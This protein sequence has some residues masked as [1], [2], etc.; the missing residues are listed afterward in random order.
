MHYIEFEYQVRLDHTSFIEGYIPKTKVPYTSK[1]FN[2]T[3]SAKAYI[4]IGGEYFYSDTVTHSYMTIADA[5]LN[6]ETVD[7]GTKTAVQNI[8]DKVV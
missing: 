8:L 5:V 6:D 3:I 7:D 4:K 2:Q 1:A